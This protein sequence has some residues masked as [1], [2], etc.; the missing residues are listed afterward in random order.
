MKA[1]LEDLIFHFGAETCRSYAAAIH[2]YT[3]EFLEKRLMDPES[4][5]ILNLE[6]REAGIRAG[7]K[8]VSWLFLSEDG[9]GNYWFVDCRDEPHVVKFLNHDPQGVESTRENLMQFL[10]S[11]PEDEH[12]DIELDDDLFISRTDLI[13]RSILDPIKLE[14]WR[15]AIRGY[16]QI[17]YLGY[18]RA[19]NPRTSD[20][21]RIQVPGAVTIEAE[22]RANFA[23]LR[24]GCVIFD[25]PP[26]GVVAIARDIAHKLRAR[27]FY[28]H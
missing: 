27:A 4:I 6:I 16:P 3:P 26:P 9:C 22:G 25:S 11:S 13:R 7:H 17:H 28:G 15:E 18:R 14:E 5:L 1:R 8:P 2:A 20:E 21:M 10:A 24:Y 23:T 19:T 12:R